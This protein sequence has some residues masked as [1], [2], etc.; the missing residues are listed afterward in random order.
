MHEKMVNFINLLIFIPNNYKY[1]YYQISTKYVKYFTIN[2]QILFYNN[3]D[4]S[5][6]IDLPS[7][8]SV[9]PKPRQEAI[10]VEINVMQSELNCLVTKRD[11]GVADSNIEPEIKKMRKDLESKKSQL[12]DQIRRS[13]W[14]KS[15]REKTKQKMND[16]KTEFPEASN[17]L[18]FKTVVGRPRL[19]TNSNSGL[20]E[21]IS[22]IALHSGSANDKRRSEAVRSCKTLDDLLSELKLL[23]YT[24]SRSALYLRLIPRRSTTIQGKRHVTTVPVKLCRA[25]ADLHKDHQDQHFCRATIN[26]LEEVASVLGPE[27]VDSTNFFLIKMKTILINVICYFICLI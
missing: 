5:A 15:Y 10:K 11:A 18:N 16:L 26:G 21:A 19:E 27:Q 13:D 8:S 23:G 17:F 14:Q 3:P 22:D 20:L 1:N 7:T 24:L 9:R 4:E 12:K 6:S 2:L 25:Q